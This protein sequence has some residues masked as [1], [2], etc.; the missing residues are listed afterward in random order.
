MAGLIQKTTEWLGWGAAAGYVEGISEDDRRLPDKIFDAELAS[1]EQS[2]PKR[3]VPVRAGEGQALRDELVGLALSGGGIRAAVFSIGV[4]QALAI[5]N[6]LRYADYLSTVSGGGYAGGALTWFLNGQGAQATPRKAVQAGPDREDA[7]SQSNNSSDWIAKY[8]EKFVR[9]MDRLTE[10]LSQLGKRPAGSRFGVCSKNF[11]FGVDRR[12]SSGPIDMADQMERD[13]ER[14]LSHL[15]QHGNYLTPGAGISAFSLVGVIMR[16]MLLNAIVWVPLSVLAMVLILSTAQWLG[17]D[18]HRVPSAESVIESIRAGTFTK[19]GVIQIA[20]LPF[21]QDWTLPEGKAGSAQD[22]VVITKYWGGTDAVRRGLRIPVMVLGTIF[23]IICVLYSLLTRV[24]REMWRRFSRWVA[25]SICP[26]MVAA[27]WTAMKAR[28]KVPRI[29]T[30]YLARRVIETQMGRIVWW[31]LLFAVLAVLPWVHELLAKYIAETG[32]A[33]LV[34]GVAT[35]LFSYL[36]SGA[37]GGTSGKKDL[38]LKVLPLAGAILFLG[39]LVLTIYWLA[40]EYVRDGSWLHG[41]PAWAILL[42]LFVSVVTG[43]IVNLNFISIH[44]Y[45]RD[46]LMETFMPDPDQAGQTGPAWGANRANLSEVCGEDGR[47]LNGPYP[48]INVNTVLVDSDRPRFRHRGGDNF[49]LSPL[50]CGSFATGWR[51]TRKFMEDKLT[52]PTAVAISGAAMHPNTGVGG[53]GPTR[54]RALSLLMALLNLRLGYWVRNPNPRKTLVD[55]GF[56]KR[57]NHFHALS[58]EILSDKYQEKAAFLQLSDGGH[59]ENLGVYELIRRRARLVICCDAGADPK[60]NFSDLRVLLSRIE[61]DFGA[62]I[63]FDGSLEASSAKAN[64]P[65]DPDLNALIPKGESQYPHLEAWLAKANTPKDA[66]LNALIPKDESQ[67]RDG[68]KLAERGHA[69]GR[70]HYRDGAEGDFIL[71]KTTMI[72]G[73]DLGVTNYKLEHTG[74]PDESTADQF[75]DE[76]QFEA[77]RVLGYDIAS[78]M[79]EDERL[80]STISDGRNVTLQGLLDELFGVTPT[81]SPPD[82]QVDAAVAGDHNT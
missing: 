58:Y 14:I 60:T 40:L 70:I 79:I 20:P 81:G 26:R 24:P 42:V 7:E 4:M 65:K 74:F 71:L 22:A 36:R 15:R 76:E 33:S 11:P 34:A 56:F 28:F 51:K 67:Y 35:G 37:D 21:A 9:R 39:G 72:K 62:T 5:K 29:T 41:W 61:E 6:V 54:N 77:Y 32:A 80:P 18:D 1:I 31:T 48:L 73:L 25:R 63:T 59:F 55:W 12:G 47:K 43:V 69:F 3:G 44:R 49:I 53:A 45:Y 78:R 16:G 30:R 50:Y 19:G 17:S 46:R 2:R 68:V 75:F 10:Y 52:L 82:F 66:E 57:P 27:G 13:Q 64:A 8:R 23:S 38:I